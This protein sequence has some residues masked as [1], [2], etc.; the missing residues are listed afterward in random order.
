[1]TIT[2][3][4]LSRIPGYTAKEGVR[5][6]LG[7][8][9]FP[10]GIP[11]IHYQPTLGKAVTETHNEIRELLSHGYPIPEDIGA[12]IAVAERYDAEQIAR[13]LEEMRA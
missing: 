1:M 10:V 3:E 12:A 9:V 13:D 8:T 11:V 7:R 4:A 6:V 2:S 5:T